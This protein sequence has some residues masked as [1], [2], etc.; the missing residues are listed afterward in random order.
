MNEEN[1]PLKR[2]FWF[3]LLAGFAALSLPLSATAQVPEAA[4]PTAPTYRYSV[5]GGFAYTSLNQVNLSRYGL[6]GGRV[7][8]TRDLGKYF[9]A[10]GS[11]DY[12]KPPSSSATP[13][14]PGNP[15]V[16]SV[17][18]GPEVHANIWGSIDGLFFGE[19]GLE[20][21]GGEGMI[22]DSSF[23]GGYGGGLLYHFGP[24]LGLQVTGDRLAASFSLNNNTPQLGYSSNRT[25]NTRATIGAVFRF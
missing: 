24:R 1:F 23:A 22:P 9:A 11:G 15:W 21:T 16:Y 19:F 2:T 10:M 12:Y 25:W 20:H 17:L 6:I 13:G 7:M 18:A 4:P 5:Y 14:N 3:P 8:L